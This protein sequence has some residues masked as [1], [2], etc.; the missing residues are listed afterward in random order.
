MSDLLLTKSTKG[1]VIFCRSHNHLVEDVK[2]PEAVKD[3]ISA[4]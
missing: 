2:E 4:R 1:C 3:Y